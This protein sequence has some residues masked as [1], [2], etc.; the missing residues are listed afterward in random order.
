M[1]RG[2]GEKHSKQREARRTRP[3]TEGAARVTGTQHGN[4]RAGVPGRVDHSG[5]SGFCLIRQ[6]AKGKL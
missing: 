4:C 6:E 3:A 5:N 2:V 1:L